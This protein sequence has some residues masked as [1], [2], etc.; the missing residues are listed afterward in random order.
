MSNA[1][2]PASTWPTGTR[3]GAGRPDRLMRHLSVGRWVIGVTSL[4]MSSLFIGVVC[5]AVGAESVAV[6]TI[7]RIAGMVLQGDGDAL[8]SVGASSVILLQ[9]R[10]PRLGLAFLVG[11]SLAVVGACLQAL[12]RNPLAEPYV[13][14]ISSGAAFGATVGLLLGVGG[15][16][17]GLSVLPVWAFCGGLL[18]ILVVYRISVTY[19]MLSVHTLLLAGVILNALF[20]ALIMFVV[21]LADPTQAFKI[22]MWLM[23]TIVA[24]SYSTLLWLAVW[25]G[26]GGVVLFGLARSLNVLTTGEETSRALGVEVERVKKL[27]F[28]VSALMTGAVVSLAG[29]IGFVGMVVPHVVRMIA[30]ADHRLLL[31]ASALVG[32]SFLMV[33]DTIAR[34]ALSPTELPVGVVTALTGGPVFMYLLVKRRAGVAV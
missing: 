31:P 26:A 25:L 32:G 22:M 10:L 19:R 29:L 8:E 3:S 23:G 14:G 13:L 24:P 5:L 7:L 20:S 15:T 1:H 6:G 9:F 17:L 28:V 18:S 4:A 27:I 12:L 21:S 16:V 33:A 34:T 2:I 30:G 11:S